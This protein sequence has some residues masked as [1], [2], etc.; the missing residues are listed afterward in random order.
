MSG[1]AGRGGGKLP[2]RGAAPSPEPQIRQCLSHP[3]PQ[4][5]SG[6]QVPH[7]LPQPVT[8]RP[9]PTVQVRTPRWTPPAR[10]PHTLLPL[11]DTATIRRPETWHPDGDQRPE[12]PSP[13]PHN[14]VSR[15][16]PPSRRLRA[17]TPGPSR[18]TPIRSAQ[19]RPRPPP[20]LDLP[21]TAQRPQ[22]RAP[23][24]TDPPEMH[25]RPPRT[26]ARHGHPRG[27]P[28][29][30][31]P[32]RLAAGGTRQPGPP[33]SQAAWAAR[34]PAGG[35]PGVT[36][37]RGACRGPGHCTPPPA[38]ARAPERRVRTW[39][40]SEA[41]ASP[42]AVATAPSPPPAPRRPR[43]PPR[44][45]P[46]PAG[47]R[48]RGG[49]ARPRHCRAPCKAIGR[50]RPPPPPSFVIRAGSRRLQLPPAA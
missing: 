36:G 25:L 4:P 34:V 40:R 21:P 12:T 32:R 48:A 38:R 50:R 29:Q 49:R 20:G 9:S 43:P 47:G 5:H 44:A 46:P 23:Q 22:A 24:A 1:G 7:T 15:D 3:Q 18:L 41:A 14:L 2:G 28:A 8:P 16:W 11:P 45:P 26:A 39:S 30:P 10:P 17:P 27:R 42:S 6:T 19:R 37:V 31:S 13:P 35:A 33:A